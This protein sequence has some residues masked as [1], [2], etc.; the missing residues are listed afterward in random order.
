MVRIALI[1]GHKSSTT[2]EVSFNT[3]GGMT[4]PLRGETLS[5]VKFSIPSSGTPFYEFR[6]NTYFIT[7][8]YGAFVFEYPV[9]MVSRNTGNFV[10]ELDHFCEIFNNAL[11]ACYLGLQALG[12]FPLSHIPRITY[13]IASGLF[14]FIVET[15]VFGTTAINPITI[16]FNDPLYRIFQGIPFSIIPLTE[17]LLFPNRVFQLIFRNIVENS[18]L[19]GFLRISQE[20]SSIA[21]FAYVREILLVSNMPVENQ[22]RVSTIGNQTSLNVVQSFTIPYENGFSDIYSNFDFVSSQNMFRPVK[23][24]TDDLYNVSFDVYYVS[25]DGNVSRL[26]IPPYTTALVE[27]EIN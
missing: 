17:T 23:L 22:V 16:I 21:N 20:G 13:N 14:N 3:I 18:Y 26:K 11:S 12:G 9:V 24:L 27:I 19:S 25:I 1:D 10:Y 8:K 6:P 15:S 4:Q 2:S 7:M 5:V